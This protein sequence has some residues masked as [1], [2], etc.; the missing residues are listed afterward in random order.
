MFSTQWSVNELAKRQFLFKLSGNGPIFSLL[1]VLQIIST[2]FMAGSATSTSTYMDEG[3]VLSFNFS[4]ISN[5]GQVGL[6]M[7]WA[8]IIGFILTSAA[9]R[10]ESFTF[11]TNRLTFQLANFYFFCAAALFGGVTTVLLGSVM[12]IIAMF[13]VNTVMETNSLL[14]SPVDFFLQIFVMTAYTLLLMLAGYTLGSF[15]QYSKLFIMLFALVYIT[16][17]QY[18]FFSIGDGS[19]SVLHFFYGETSILLFTL[20][21][22]LAVAVLFATSFWVTNRLEVRNS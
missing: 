3:N 8:F 13:H 21:I 1:I 20:K 2:V 18:T 6:T 16:F 9:Q 5:D 14:S 11:V 22:L 17:T 4:T 19:D 10:N 15:I 7:F 12:K